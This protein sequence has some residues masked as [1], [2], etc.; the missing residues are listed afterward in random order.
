MTEQQKGKIKFDTVT[1]WDSW[2]A[3]WM[4]A[5]ERKEQTQ[6]NME[7]AHKEVLDALYDPFKSKYHAQTFVDS[8]K[9]LRQKGVEL[10]IPED[11]AKIEQKEAEAA[12]IAEY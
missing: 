3:F 2:D 4:S 1:R 9:V 10:L 12:K 11:R 6:A 8:M 5:E 7:K